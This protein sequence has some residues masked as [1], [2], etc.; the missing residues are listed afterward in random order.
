[1]DNIDLNV[2]E[3]IVGV[4]ASANR[5]RDLQKFMI[6]RLLTDEQEFID[7]IP[8]IKWANGKVAQLQYRT[9]SDGLV[10]LTKEN[11]YKMVERF[12][13]LETNNARGIALR[14]KRYIFEKYCKGEELKDTQV[15]KWKLNEG[16]SDY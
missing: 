9:V 3:E 4:L 5:R 6:V 1:M 2:A 11:F 13:E 8:D 16:N 12:K 7:K 14:H 15:L 10:T